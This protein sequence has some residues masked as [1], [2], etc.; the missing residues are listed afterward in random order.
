MLGEAKEYIS[1]AYKIRRCRKA[2]AM[3]SQRLDKQWKLSCVLLM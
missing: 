1:N 3:A 2:L